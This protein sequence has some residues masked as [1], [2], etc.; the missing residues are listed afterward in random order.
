MNRILEKAQTEL[1]KGNLWRAKE[2]LQGAIRSE[3]YNVQLFE[4]LGTVFLKMGDLAEAGR[5]LF[6]SGVRKPE[7]L[8][9]LEIFLSRHGKKEPRN[10][11]YLL[12]RKARLKTL[13][14]YPSEV[15]QML[16]EM[17]FPEIL[18]NEDG[19]VYF[20]KTGSDIPFFI[21]CGII[22]LVILV[23]IILGIIKFHEIIR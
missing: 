21:T 13:S 19:K 9:A 8:E 16:R 15:A 11:I 17:G 12:P 14:D 6:L 4:M 1:E 3:S 23:L 5:F 10:F 22:A 7:Y 18:K 2:I 20:P